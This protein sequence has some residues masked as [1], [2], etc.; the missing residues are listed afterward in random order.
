MPFPFKA[1][2]VTASNLLLLGGDEVGA[3]GWEGVNYSPVESSV[4]L[5]PCRETV[6]LG[7]L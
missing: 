6:S 5:A 7:F 2:T 1:D 4:S 3:G